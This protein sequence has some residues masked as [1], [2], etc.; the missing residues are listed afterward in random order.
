VGIVPLVL[1]A[2]DGH[3]ISALFTRK[4]G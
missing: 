1:S 3:E 2:A 4:N